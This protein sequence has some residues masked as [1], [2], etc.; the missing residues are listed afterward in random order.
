M[1]TGREMSG[2]EKVWR[3]VIQDVLCVDKLLW[4]RGGQPQNRNAF[5]DDI[6]EYLTSIEASCSVIRQSLSASDGA[7]LSGQQ[8]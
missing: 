1:G 6:G 5:K 7:K 3:G 2:D 8:S 4:H